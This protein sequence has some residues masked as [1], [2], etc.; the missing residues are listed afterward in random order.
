VKSRGIAAPDGL[1]FTAKV[2]QILEN[3]VVVEP[4]AGKSVLNTADRISFVTKGLDD[5]GAAVG[6][7][8]TVAYTGVLTE[9]YP[10]RITA[11]WWV[12]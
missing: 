9:T 2:L 6:D 12:K 8:V 4:L 5:I 11:V 7:V 10:A 1:V 3:S